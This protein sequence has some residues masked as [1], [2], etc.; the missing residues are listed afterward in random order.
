VPFTAQ[1]TAEF[2]FPETVAENGNES[3]ARIFAVVGVTVT[4]VVEG[5]EGVVGVEGLLLDVVV[6]LQP[7]SNSAAKM[8][9]DFL[10]I[11]WGAPEFACRLIFSDG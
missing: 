10:V 3:P 8:E 7:Q 2:E 6:P 11:D 5:V 9:S 4:E 1:L